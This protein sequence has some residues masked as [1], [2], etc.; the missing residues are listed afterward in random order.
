MK[1]HKLWNGRALC[2]VK[3]PRLV[4]TTDN[5]T[6]ETCKKILAKGWGL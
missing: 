4:L 1:Y 6:C 5:V 3:S 2:G